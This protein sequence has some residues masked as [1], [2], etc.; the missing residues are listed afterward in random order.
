MVAFLPSLSHSKSPIL[1]LELSNQSSLTSPLSDLSAPNV[2]QPS[3]MSLIFLLES[4][5]KT[6]LTPS[7]QL[8]QSGKDQYQKWHG[9]WKAE[10]PM[11]Q[12][13]QQ[14]S[15]PSLPC[16]WPYVFRSHKFEI[17]DNWDRLSWGL[18]SR[19][20]EKTLNKLSE[21]MT[22]KERY[23]TYLREDAFKVFQK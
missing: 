18:P 23:L 11:F 12:R 22:F 1:L 16:S 8:T 9:R 5:R 3:A 21:L 13:S 15:S 6:F 17:N 19:I 7:S 4:W 14:E 20:K 2:L 10:T